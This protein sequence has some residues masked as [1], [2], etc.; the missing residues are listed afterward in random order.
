VTGTSPQERA[1]KSYGD[2]A[3]ETVDEVGAQILEAA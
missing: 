3:R 1:V 2:G